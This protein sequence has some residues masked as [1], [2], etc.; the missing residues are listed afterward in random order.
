MVSSTQEDLARQRV[1]A[2]ALQA[3]KALLQSVEAR[4]TQQLSGLQHEQASHSLLLANLQT[5]QVGVSQLTCRPYRW[6]SH[7]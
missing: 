1:K 7:S 5:I 4:L 2:D 6:A 3:D